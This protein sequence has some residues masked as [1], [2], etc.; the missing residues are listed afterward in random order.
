MAETWDMR[1]TP[2][3]RQVTGNI[4]VV[5]PKDATEPTVLLIEG[6]T[7]IGPLA[8]QVTEIAACELAAVLNKH[9][10]TRG[11]SS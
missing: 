1:Q 11:S 2:L 5:D 4:R 3:I 9:P 7:D 10:L 6:L 8:L